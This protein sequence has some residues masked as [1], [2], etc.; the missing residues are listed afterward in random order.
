MDTQAPKLTDLPNELLSLIFEYLDID[1]LLRLSMTCRVLHYVALPAFFEQNDVKELASGWV[2][3]YRAPRTTLQALRM[4]LFVEKLDQIHYYL[5]PGLDRLLGE[6]RDL[7]GLVERLLSVDQV[8]LHFV[9]FDTW[10]ANPPPVN[11]ERPRLDVDMWRKEFS[12][13]LDQFLVRGC[14][15]LHITGGSRIRTIYTYS[16]ETMKPVTPFAT[17]VAQLRSRLARSL[18]PLKKREAK[19]A[20]RTFFG[21]LRRK[22]TSLF[23]NAV[24]AKAPLQSTTSLEGPVNPLPPVTGVPQ[25]VSSDAGIKPSLHEFYLHCGMLLQSPFLEWTLSTLQLNGECITVLSFKSIDIP[26][27]AWSDF[28]AALTFPSLF[29]FEITSDLIMRPQG[30]EFPCIESFLT[31]HP[32]ITLLLLHGLLIPSTFPPAQESILPNLV[33]LTAHPAYISWL[34]SSPKSLPCLNSITISS[35]YYFT[36]DFEYAH[37]DDA[38]ISIARNAGQVELGICFRSQNGVDAWFQEHVNIGCKVSAVSQLTEIKNLDICL[39]WFVEFS[40]RTLEILPEFLALFPSLEHVGLMEQPERNERV[41]LAGGFVKAIAVRCPHIKTVAINR[42]PL[43]RLCEGA[44]RN[45]L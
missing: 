6:V 34:L 2:F 28:F 22:F 16:Q 27:E 36:P 3:L 37:F 24:P 26:S 13:M 41:M 17:D 42:L 30:P 15:K 39:S 33:K 40:E 23:C 5:N 38:L 10:L 9:M 32:S 21:A 7:R 8:Q 20:S 29:E 43:Q 45:H 4:A 18:Q 14:K 44:D 1:S 12:S 25:P 35:D 31:R 11:E 19:L